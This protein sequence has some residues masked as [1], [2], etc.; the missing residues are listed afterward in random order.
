[1]PIALDH[2]ILPVKDLEESLRFYTGLLGL[3]DAG[4]R[5]PFSVVRV[6]E[7]CVIQL[8]PWGTSGGGHLAFSMTQAEF[9]ETFR[10]IREAG[11]KYGDAFDAAGNM[12]GPGDAEG[13]RGETRS[14]YCMDPNDHLIEIVYYERGG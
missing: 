11:L 9:D 13:A 1:M 6:T 7:E 2:L 5:E 10:R 4:K 8:A 12:K 3:T 14:L